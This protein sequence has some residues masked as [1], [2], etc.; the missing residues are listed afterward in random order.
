MFDVTGMLPPEWR[1]D[2]LVATAGSDDRDF[3]QIPVISR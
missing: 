1:Q 3:P 2:V